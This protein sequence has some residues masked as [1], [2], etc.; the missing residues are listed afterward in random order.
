M[1]APYA[2]VHPD[3]FKRTITAQGG[4]KDDVIERAINTASRLIE[5]ELGRRLRYRSPAE[6]ENAANTVADVALAVGS[7]TVAEQ[8]DSSGRTLI[9]SLT[10]ADR[11]VKVGTVTVTG[12]VGG[13]AAQTE[14]FTLSDGPRLHGR[15]FFSAI[16]GI[17]VAGVTQPTGGADTIRIGTSLGMVEYHTP[18]DP[19]TIRLLERPYM[20]AELN[21]DPV[22]LEY[23]ALTALVHDVDYRFAFDGLVTRIDS[24][25]AYA[26]RSGYR[27]LK[28]RYSG[29][30]GALSTIP[31]DLRQ[32]CISIAAP[33]YQEMNRADVGMQTQSDALGNFTRFGP[34]GVLTQG[35]KDALAEY[36]KPDLFYATGQRD[37]DLE[38]V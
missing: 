31:D 26:W 23:A 38:A 34:S 7:L 14:V 32:L 18:R 8:P 37:F 35:H 33:M 11:S 6:Q 22:D 27:A 5:A 13:V 17:T 16:S 24:R 29:T 12:T 28:A 20:I 9:V 3:E 2:L 25:R 4:S 19:Y 1:L 15:K 10:D 21:E 36:R 30:Y